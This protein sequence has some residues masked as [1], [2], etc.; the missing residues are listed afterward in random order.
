MRDLLQILERE[1][2]TQ[3]GPSMGDRVRH[4][5]RFREKTDALIGLIYNR[6]GFSHHKRA[7][8]L[9]EASTTSD[10][11]LLFGNILER[12]LKAKYEIAAPDW[13]TYLGV[14]SQRDFR[15]S[16]IL[17]IFGLQTR[18]KKVVQ[19]GPYLQDEELDEGKVSIVVSKFGRTFGLAWETIVNDDLGAFQDVPERLANAARL[20][21]YLE[22]TELFVDSSGPH[23]SLYGATVTHPIDGA[24]IT[25]KGVLPFDAAGLGKTI[26]LMRQQKDTDGNPIIMSGFELVVP[27]A[28]EI[29]MLEALNAAAVVVAGTADIVRTSANVVAGLGIRGHVNPYLPIV[30][31][32]S[33]DKTWYLFA[34]LPTGPAAQM[35]FMRGREAPE[36]VMKAPNKVGAANPLDGDF[37]TDSMKWRIR[38]IMGG[39]QLDPRATFAQVAP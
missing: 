5:T 22:A 23:A 28:L 38:H 21:E 27:P 7:L 3:M 1:G 15:S 18:L 32:A 13:R 19:R 12:Q 25:N 2:G 16:D 30:D 35:N 24:A 17:A 9:E 10:F 33:P 37:E 34:K 31:G 14:G 4:V 29:A 8:L 6:A 26:Q 20:T 11:P 39:T 36:L